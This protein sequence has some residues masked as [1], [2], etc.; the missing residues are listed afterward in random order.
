MKTAKKQTNS[1]FRS[2]RASAG[3]SL[4]ELLIAIFILVIGIIGVMYMFP[5]GVQVAK[6]AQMTSV[7]VQLGQIKMEETITKH[8]DDILTG[9]TIEPYDSI[10][11]FNHYK[12]IT[13]ISCVDPSLNQVGCDYDSIDLNPM[14]KIEVSLFW[15]SPLGSLEQNVNLV[16]LISKK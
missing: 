6:S 5:M 7:A 10:A 11:G 16:S 2:A 4:I 1:F 14:K 3:F 8:Y 13:E 9:E 15:K 12:R